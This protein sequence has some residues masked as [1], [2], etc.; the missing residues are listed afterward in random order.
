MPLDAMKD[1][2]VVEAS[3]FYDSVAFNG[4]WEGVKPAP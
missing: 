1:G 2:W 4:F 3:A